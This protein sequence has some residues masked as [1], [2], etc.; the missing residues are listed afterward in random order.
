MVRMGHIPLD[1]TFDSLQVDLP[2][3][4][5]A[6]VG[7]QQVDHLLGQ[8]GQDVGGVQH[9]EGTQGAGLDHVAD[10]PHQFL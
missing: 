4:P 8:A 10:R 5:V 3:V 2:Q 9:L 1:V 6:A 7:G